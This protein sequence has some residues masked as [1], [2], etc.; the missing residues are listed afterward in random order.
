MVARKAES[1]LAFRSGEK[2]KGRTIRQPGPR[3]ISYEFYWKATDSELG[4]A[5]SMES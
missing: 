1:S 2:L 4:I 3:E 5:Q